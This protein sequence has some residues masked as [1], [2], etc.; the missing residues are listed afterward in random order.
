MGIGAPIDPA[1]RPG[2]RRPEHPR[3]LLQFAR[4]LIPER[5][6]LRALPVGTVAVLA[7]LLQRHRRTAFVL[8]GIVAAQA[9]GW[10]AV[11]GPQIPGTWLRRLQLP[12]RPRSPA[13]RLASRP[14]PR[15]SPLRAWSAGSPDVPCVPALPAGTDVPVRRGYLVCYHAQ[16]GHR[17]VPPAD[18]HCPHRRAGRAAAR[19]AHYPRQRRLGLPAE[20]ATGH[21]HGPGTWWHGA[22]SGVG[23]SG[24]GVAAGPRRLSLRLAHGCHGRQGLRG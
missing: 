9:V 11:W 10:A 2:G 3:R 15:W 13:C 12:R 4:P 1:P 21:Q 8:A 16:F 6:P 18:Q 17:D 7:W 24:R 22:T 5:A 20:P 19:Q 14:R 23:R